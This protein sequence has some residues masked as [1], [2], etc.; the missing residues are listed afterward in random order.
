MTKQE[1]TVA[2][3]D[4]GAFAQR[5]VGNAKFNDVETYLLNAGEGT[6]PLR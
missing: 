2:D 1:L 6:A 3:P 5:I 4:C